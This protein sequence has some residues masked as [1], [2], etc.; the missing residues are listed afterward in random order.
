VLVENYKVGALTRYG[1]GY[2][3]LH[4]VNPRLVYCSITGFGQNGPYANLPGYDYVFQGMSG[5]M[6]M[7]GV[8]EG[9][10][11]A[12]PMKSGLAIADLLTGMYATSAILAA[13]EHRHISGKGQHIDLALLD[14]MVAINS[15]QAANY[16]LS[17]KVPHRMG[18]AHSNLVPYQ[19]FRCRE[20]EIIVAVGNDSQF[21][22]L[23]RVLGCPELGVDPLYA[24]A[25]QR[26]RNRATLIP[27]VARTLLERTMD[28]WVPLLIDANVPCGPILNMQ[29]VFENSQVLHRG[30]KVSLPHDL[31]G[32]V[33]GVANPIRL[34]D[35]PVRYTHSAPTLG[36]S[37]DAILGER[38]GIDKARI[39]ALRAN[40]IV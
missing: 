27:Q 36:N 22:D 10:P 35:T 4:K 1:L 31:G 14:C 28:E 37:N 33:P 11:G 2:D 3:D 7:T 34:S 39:D 32:E 18:N 30:M 23:C 26:N 16:F 29:Q 19:V 6:S 17:G 8:P 9:E 20:G 24:T 5:L 40:G 21:R 13:L 38:L 25:S 15:Y 12:A